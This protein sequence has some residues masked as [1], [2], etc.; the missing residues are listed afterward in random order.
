MQTL[1]DQIAVVTGASGGI[2]SAIVHALAERG[3]SLC[4]AGRDPSKLGA[5]ACSLTAAPSTIHSRPM[6][7]T[8]DGDIEGLAQFV[9]D[10][11]GRLDILIH[12][13][14][15][16]R[17]GNLESTPIASLDQQYAANVR[18]P[19]LLTQMLVPLLKRPCGQVVFINSSLGLAARANTGHFAAT[20]HAFK[21]IADSLREEL[22]IESVRVLS[23]FTGRTAT[24]RIQM[25]DASQGRPY[26][27]E[28][29]LQPAD[30]ASVVL[31]ALSLPWT[32]EVTDINIRPM[33]K[34][35]VP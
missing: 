5:V 24:S 3:V 18:G 9:N 4:L 30:V 15:A 27:P 26:R 19:L 13:A 8:K 23:V 31:N 10:Q 16:I 35:A 11:Y 12:C 34:P 29:L 20:Q 1:N 25:L 33:R 22:N 21:A 2:G 6:D 28:L 14:G 17:H 7:L 32:A